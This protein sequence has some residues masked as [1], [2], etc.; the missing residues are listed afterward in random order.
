[1]N[2]N[3][4]LAVVCMAAGI[5]MLLLSCFLKMHQS[6]A[7]AA[8]TLTGYRILIDPG[9]GGFDGGAIGASGT[10]ESDIN[11]QIAQALQAQLCKQGA[12]VIM[13]RSTAEA[14]GTDKNEDMRNRRSMIETS[15]QQIT[16][17]IH[18]NSFPDASVSGPQVIYA[19]GSVQGEQLADHIQAQMNSSLLPEKPRVST[20]GDYYIVKSGSAP[21][22]IVECGFLS[23][24][25]EEALLCKQN[26][27]Q[28]VA[29]AIAAGVTQY[30]AQEQEVDH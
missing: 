17:S 15:G 29:Q 10:H 4:K 14:V 30:F 25:T 12:E 18:Q 11:L 19:P 27:Q 6:P 1:M 16:I 2:R 28:R 23:N 3:R 13:T 7:A 9:H 5:L 8:Q 21:A 20:Q 22:V 24:S 26:Y